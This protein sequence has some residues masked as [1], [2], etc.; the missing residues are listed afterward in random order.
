MSDKAVI[1]DN[2]AYEIVIP[3]VESEYDENYAKYG[4]NFN[5]CIRTKVL[6]SVKSEYNKVKGVFVANINADKDLAKSTY[7]PNLHKLGANKLVCGLVTSPCEGT[8]IY[9]EKSKYKNRYSMTIYIDDSQAI[10]FD[11]L[12][13]IFYGLEEGS[14]IFVGDKIGLYYVPAGNAK[15]IVPY[16]I[17]SYATNIPSKIPVRVW[18]MTYYKHNPMDKLYQT[19]ESNIATINNDVPGDLGMEF[20]VPNTMVDN[21]ILNNTVEKKTGIWSGVSDL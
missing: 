5:A 20:P 11:N 1:L 3:Y 9:I 12:C 16:L 18:D 8:I 15:D 14:K 17:F 6:T 21:I 2:S 13:Y 4:F 10:M 7:F 19:I